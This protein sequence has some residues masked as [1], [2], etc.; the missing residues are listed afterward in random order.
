MNI[1]DDLL[2]QQW[3]DHSPATPQ[4][5]IRQKVVPAPTPAN[6]TVKVL[7]VCDTSKVSSPLYS[8]K[9]H[10]HSILLDTTLAAPS[11]ALKHFHVAI[12]AL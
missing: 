8:N 2:P 11:E 7:P 9:Q 3:Q 1:P 12:L 5:R 4:D 10:S 6:V